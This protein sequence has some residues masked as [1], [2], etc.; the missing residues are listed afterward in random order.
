MKRA[1]VLPAHCGRTPR[2]SH[3]DRSTLIAYRLPARTARGRSGR[4]GRG[5]EG[6]MPI[7]SRRTQCTRSKRSAAVGP[8]GLRRAVR[9]RLQSVRRP[10]REEKMDR[11]RQGRPTP[12][13][14]ECGSGTVMSRSGQD[15]HSA[16]PSARGSGP[17]LPTNPIASPIAAGR[18]ADDAALVVPPT[19]PYGCDPCPPEP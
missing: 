6:Q 17:W 2:F 3:P 13:R 4:R 19:T 14:S 18:L 12:R 16:S 1:R 9:V 8:C 15:P 10:L 5:Q 7:A 11:R